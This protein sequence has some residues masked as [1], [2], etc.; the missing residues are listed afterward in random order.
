[1]LKGE[2]GLW[3]LLILLAFTGGIASAYGAARA[4]G[5]ELFS[6]FVALFA[7]FLV[8]LVAFSAFT[9]IGDWLHKRSPSSPPN[10]PATFWSEFPFMLL[11]IMTFVG[12]IAAINVT[13]ALTLRFL[14]HAAT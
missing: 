4:S 3:P 7:G 10:H 12:I 11:Y 6:T 13:C 1:L 8:G 5:T 9:R 2:V 14:R